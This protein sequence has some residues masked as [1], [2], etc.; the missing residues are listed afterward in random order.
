MTPSTRAARK[1]ADCVVELEHLDSQR[2]KLC[3]ELALDSGDIDQFLSDQQ[4][5]T[6]PRLWESF[7]IRLEECKETNA[8][9]GAF[10][11]IRR[12][13]VEKALQILRGSPEKL[14]LYGPD[15]QNEQKDASHLGRA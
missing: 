6:P 8:V 9:N 10:T 12:S 5:R 7:L 14:G 15:G 1:K 13:H 2:A 11:R 4:T 3:R